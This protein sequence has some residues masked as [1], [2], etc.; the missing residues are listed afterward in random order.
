MDVDRLY[1]SFLAIARTGAL[2]RAARQ[3]GCSTASISRQLDALESHLCVRLFDRTTRSVRLSEAGRRLLP[4]AEAVLQALEDARHSVDAQRVQA[5][6]RVSAPI[7]L[8]VE[9]VSRCLASLCRVQP[10]LQIDLVL[11]NRR[12]DPMADG[13]DILVRS[14]LRMPDEPDLVVREVGS[15]DLGI[16][17]GSHVAKTISRTALP[18]EVALL[19]WIGHRGFSLDRGLVLR[20]DD[21][22]VLLRVQPWLWSSDILAIAR[23]AEQGDSCAILPHWLAKASVAQ[24]ALKAV[25]T[26]WRLPA[27]Q[28]WL[29][30]RNRGS[31]RESVAQVAHHLREQLATLAT[32]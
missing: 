8:G 11:E 5:S 15:L 9:C 31:N 14:G 20:R 1:G 3:L 18:Q 30:W 6:V 16:Y 26:D 17:A 29:A 10:G 32:E 23:M 25:L 24:G 7:A 4:K 13:V 19:P 28:I 2:S 12:S 21:D 22:E 27:A